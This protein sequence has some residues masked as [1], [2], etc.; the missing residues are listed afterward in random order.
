MIKLS[1]QTL[2]FKQS[3]ASG[4]YD[5]FDLIR[6]A[7]DL[8]YDGVDLEDRQFASTEAEYLEQLRLHALKLGMP[9]GYIGIGGGFGQGWY[10]DDEGH[11]AHIKAWTDV[12]RAMQ[13]PLLRVIGCGASLNESEEDA[14]PR[15]EEHMRDITAHARERGV[16]I[17]LHN[18]NHGM[19]PATAAQIQ[20]ML[21][22]VNDPYFVHILDTGQYRGSPGASRYAEDPEREKYDLYASIA[23]SLDR[24]LTVR[25]KI[26]AIGTGEEAWLD[27]RRIMRILKGSGF[28][29]W[30]S[31]V[32]EGRDG[33]PDMRAMTLAHAYLRGLLS[34]F[35]I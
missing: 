29:G 12:A 9:I 28:K 27:Y 25:A 24:A 13:V 34:E 10:G 1:M 23:G 31:V 18:H 22:E 7:A 5:L 32:Y 6:I 15:T 17:G 16:L 4:E 3:A 20:R 35:E 2:S 26:Y 33:T 11:T 21:D 30:L 14:W 19:F 8:G